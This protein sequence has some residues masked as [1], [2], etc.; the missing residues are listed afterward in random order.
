[1]ATS[2]DKFLDPKSESETRNIAKLFITKNF[3]SLSDFYE[4]KKYNH[5]DEGS[6]QSL[7]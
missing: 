2:P 5:A 7:S 1:M 4:R 6:L 3:L